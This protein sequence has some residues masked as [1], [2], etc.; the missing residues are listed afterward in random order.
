MRMARRPDQ[1]SPTDRN[2]SAGR[3]RSGGNG[4][5]SSTAWGN[6]DDGGGGQKL[7]ARRHFVDV[8]NIV[9]NLTP[10]GALCILFA[11][12]VAN[13][14]LI[15]PRFV[16]AGLVSLLKNEPTGVDSTDVRHTHTMDCWLVWR[17]TR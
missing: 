14:W 1:L 7:S 9:L 13:S 4:G 11:L 6:D 3:D 2:G 8:E 15:P 16:R 17:P 12:R 10:M 5:G